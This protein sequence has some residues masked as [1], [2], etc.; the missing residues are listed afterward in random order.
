MSDNPITVSPATA[1]MVDGSFREDIMVGVPAASAR[2]FIFVGESED[3]GIAHNNERYLGAVALLENHGMSVIEGVLL[4][5]T[6]E[7]G[8]Q[9]QVH[10]TTYEEKGFVHYPLDD[11]LTKPDIEGAD[12]PYLN[13]DGTAWLFRHT[14]AGFHRDMIASG[15]NTIH[16]AF[17]ETIDDLTV[18]LLAPA[19]NSETYSERYIALSNLVKFRDACDTEV[20]KIL[21]GKHLG[22]FHQNEHGEHLEPAARDAI[23]NC[24]KTWAANQRVAYRTFSSLIPGITRSITSTH[25]PRARWYKPPAKE[26]SSDE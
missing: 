9:F 21:E 16:R 1:Y 3:L 5:G 17:G 20:T 8:W 18:K 7:Y 13:E 11:R 4:H 10:N 2:K 23:A 22:Y 15:R 24:Q 6:Q 26:T 19:L 14:D 25:E 12:T